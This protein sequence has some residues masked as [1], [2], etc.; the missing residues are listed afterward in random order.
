MIQVFLLY[1][2]KLVRYISVMDGMRVVQN[3]I[4]S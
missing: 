4:G 2:D 1:K 3:F